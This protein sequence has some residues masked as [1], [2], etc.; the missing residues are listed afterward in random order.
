[1]GAGALFAAGT[2]LSVGTQIMGAYASKKASKNE[3]Q[4]Y[5]LQSDELELQKGILTDQY[6]QQ[7]QKLQGDAVAAAGANGVKVSGSVAESISNSLT[8]LGL[9]DSYRKFNLSMEQNNLA[10]ESKMSKVNSRN[11]FY[12]SLLNAGA[13]GLKGYATYDKYWGSSDSKDNE[14]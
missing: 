1:M 13:S 9:E 3:R 7:R 12:A 5:A 4:Q 8:Q 14:E 2:A 11:Q 6:R 10:Y